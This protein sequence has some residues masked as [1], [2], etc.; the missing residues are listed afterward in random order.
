MRK[1][2]DGSTDFADLNLFACLLKTFDLTIDFIKPQR[3]LQAETRDIRMH[4]VGTA[5][6]WC[7]FVFDCLIFQCFFQNQ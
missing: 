4:A 7:M 1:C 3:K 5:D 2:P 6:A